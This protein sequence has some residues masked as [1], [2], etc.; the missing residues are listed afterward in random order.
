[1][2]KTIYFNQILRRAAKD[3]YQQISWFDFSSENSISRNLLGTVAYCLIE[4]RILSGVLQSTTTH[5]GLC[6]C[7]VLLRLAAEQPTKYG[8]DLAA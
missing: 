5:L 7:N 1:M 4:I 2:L 8:G 6:D 3:L